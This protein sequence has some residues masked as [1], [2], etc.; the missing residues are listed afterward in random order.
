MNRE[1]GDLEEVEADGLRRGV[2]T[3]LEVSFV[4]GGLAS[5]A[6]SDC[7]SISDCPTGPDSGMSSR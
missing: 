1:L 5:V 4:T 2:P 6:E 7:S 3:R